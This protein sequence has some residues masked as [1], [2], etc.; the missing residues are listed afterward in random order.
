[1]K[2]KLLLTTLAGTVCTLLFLSLSIG[3]KAAPTFSGHAAV[4]FAG[5]PALVMVDSP[6]NDVGM[7]NQV[8]FISNGVTITVP[9]FAPGSL[10][11]WNMITGYVQYDSSSDTLYVGVIC[12][13]ICGDADGDGDAGTTGAI[14]GKP[15]T[16]G[17]LGGQDVADL[18]EG[19]SFGLLID[20]NNDPTT[21]EVVAGVKDS[22][23]ISAPGVYNFLGLSDTAGDALN[24]QDWGDP[25][26][27]PIAFFASPNASAPDLEFT[28]A[29]FSTLP[30][31]V[32]GTVPQTISMLMAIGSFA[33]DGIGEDAMTGRLVVAPT[34]TPTVPITAT[35][36]ITPTPTVVVTPPVTPTLTPTVT[37]PPPTD[38]PVTGGNLASFSVNANT[39][40]ILSKPQVRSSTQTGDAAGL[41]QQHSYRLQI[42]ALHLNAAIQEK[43]WHLAQNESG[44]QVSQW[45]EVEH[46]VGW[47]KNSARPAS[48]GNVV[49]SGHNNIGGSV[50]GDLYQLQGG[51]TIFVWKDNIRYAYV[52]D[53]ITILP[54]RYASV[55]ERAITTSYIQNTDDHRLT[56]MT[57]WPP[58]SD[59]HRLFVVAHL[60]PAQVWVDRRQ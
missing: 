12:A 15:V 23:S 47:H 55:E 44:E 19:E 27:N 4:D 49:M 16:E 50:F 26:P 10:T 53:E 52:V 2:P 35:V 51:E 40:G 9:A 41:M 18:G 36:P 7:P 33:D 45:D 22:S 3:T 25:L 13:T 14:L 32:N 42:P 31:F 39:A 1:M 56:L 46:A 34:P 5:Q 30:G 8:T 59:S 54:E 43:G 20:T 48:R 29:Q 11:G 57:C 38:V 37:P 24:E 58:F 17:G 60:E 21:Y 6:P 28:I